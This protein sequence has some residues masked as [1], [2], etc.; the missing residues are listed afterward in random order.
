MSDYMF[1]LE[2][3][4]SAEQFRVVGELQELAAQAGTNLFLTGGALRDMLGGFPVRDLDFTVEGNALKLAKAAAQKHGAVILS[5]DDLHK[6][7]EMRFP[8]GVTAEVAMARSEK[9]PKSGG[10]PQ[11][12]PATIH[13]DLRCRDF[14]VNAVALSLNRASLG[15]PIDPTNGV[16]DIER[17]EL[18][19][20][21][22][23]SFYDDPSRMLRLIR[24]KVRL[25]YTIDERT[26]SQYENAREA[27]MLSRIGPE[28]LGRELRHMANEPSAGDLMRAFE[29]EKL[30]Q[31]YSPALVGPKLNL[32]NFAKLQKARQLA[33]FGV[34]LRM[35]S[36]P[37]F[38]TVLM[39]KLNP[40]ERSALIKT[41]A[42]TKQEVSAWQRLEGASKKL[43]RELKSPKLQKP[44][45]LYQVLVKAPGELVLY[46]VVYSTQRIVQDRI[47]N[48]FQKYL[49]ASL[50]ITDELV[51]ATGVTPGTPKFHRAK[52]EMILTRLDARPKKPPPE[53]APP[54]PPPMSSFARGPGVRHAR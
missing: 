32:Q 30:I 44:S 36:M 50:E 46:L 22:N 15:L 7:A 9:F 25:G 49:P 12:T 42:L 54:P 51:A 27:D 2:S 1:M 37:L 38:L 19:T 10:R 16:G 28:A 53:P 21:H 43:E 34:D 8:D 29:E 26:R 40:K 39:E 4:L 33:P 35:N 47:R 31:L 48:Y 5:T 18:R 6:S 3:H 13:E 23:Y 41:A 11:V 20:I 52:E 17:K 14:T 45:H 24:F